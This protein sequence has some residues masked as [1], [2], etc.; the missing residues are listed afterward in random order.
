VVFSQGQLHEI[1]GAKAQR[2]NHCVLGGDGGESIHPAT[3]SP[4]IS[5]DSNRFDCLVEKTGFR[6]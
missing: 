2:Q 6:C 5:V 3:N 4:G 1:C